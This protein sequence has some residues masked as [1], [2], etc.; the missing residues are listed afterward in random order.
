MTLWPTSQRARWCAAGVALLAVLCYLDALP[1]G[2][3]SDDQHLILRHPY[4]KRVADWPAI[5]TAGHYDGKGGYRPITTLSFA[6]NYLLGG[7]SPIGYHFVNIV[8][9]A[10]NSALVLLLLDRILRSP[11]AALTGAALFAVHPVHT[12]AVA[13]IS[14]RAELLAT[15]FFLLAWIFHLEGGKAQRPRWALLSVSSVAL[16]VAILSKENALVFP[17][18][19]IFGDVLIQRSTRLERA[20][21]GRTRLVHYL[22]YVSVISFYFVF[23]SI[24]YPTGVLRAPAQVDFIDNPLAHVAWAAR[25]LTAL[26]VQADYLALLI[27]PKNLCGDYS[28][29]AVPLVTDVLDPRIVL[30]L[31]GSAFLLALAAWSFLTRGR[32]WFGLVFYA[33]AILPASNLLTSIGTIK[34]ERLLYLPSLGFCLIVGLVTSALYGKWKTA[35]TNPKM[36]RAP[37]GLMAASILLIGV[38]Q[39]WGRN[40]IWRSEEIFWTNTA[41]A[42]PNNYKAQLKAGDYAMKNNRM[43]EAIEA[44]RRARKVYPKSEDAVINLGVALIRSGQNSAAVALYE[45]AV[46]QNPE[47]AAFHVD[48]GLAYLTNG[49]TAAGLRELER[50]TQLQPGNAVL[51]F[52]LGRGLSMSGN[53]GAAETEYRRAIELQADYAEAWNALGAVLIKLHRAP[54]ARSALHQALQLRPQYADAIYN[55]RLID[56]QP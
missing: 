40:K 41:L 28:F 39:T 18:A 21:H 51:R 34:A 8:L 23:R 2:F 22:T 5:F 48:L 17:V 38:S 44:F 29:N 24:L 15:F 36:A 20:P 30:I 45:E 19:V 46:A 53:T 14:G 43:L 55:L 54:E 33:L 7:E 1:N 52:N 11:L 31:V 50:A 16:L 25:I 37:A 4:T 27:W 26:N 42:S 49:E 3:V 35:L 56:N 10:L 12:E 47:R 9:H 32:L 13:W 6:V